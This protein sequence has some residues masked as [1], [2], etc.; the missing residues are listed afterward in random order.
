MEN[1]EKKKEGVS[2][3]EL[4][5]Y[6][7]NH[8]F[9][10]FFC[11]LFILASLFTLVFWGSTLSIFLS[12]LGGIVSVFMPAKIDSFSKKMAHKVFSKD[13][14]TLLI[15]GIAALVA[16]IFLA[17]IIFLLIGLHAG[18]SMLHLA[19]DSSQNKNSSV[20]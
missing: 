16:A 20:Q 6:A 14:T 4:E 8:H 15:I 9:E 13:A 3:K 5:N 19:R 17:P 12:G 7:K 1:E 18:K 2:I 11:I 10:I